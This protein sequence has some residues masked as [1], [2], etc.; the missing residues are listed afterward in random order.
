MVI[1][2]KNIHPLPLLH[3]LPK[4]LVALSAMIVFLYLFHSQNLALLIVVSA[5]IYFGV[6]YLVKGFQKDDI[7]LIKNVLTKIQS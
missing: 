2:S 5:G 7:Q 6:L 4:P 1:I 3:I